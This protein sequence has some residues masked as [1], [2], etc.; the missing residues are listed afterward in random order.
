M[1]GIDYNLYRLL[2]NSHGGNQQFEF[3]DSGWII[4]ISIIQDQIKTLDQKLQVL[5][6]PLQVRSS[7]T[8]HYMRKRSI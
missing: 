3:S 7:I 6:L 8:V 4:V 5:F 1:H 2:F